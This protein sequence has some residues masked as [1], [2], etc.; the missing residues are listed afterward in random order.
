VN[1][2]DVSSPEADCE[3]ETPDNVDD[4]ALKYSVP[5]LVKALAEAGVTV[6]KGQRQEI[7]LLFTVTLVN[8]TVLEGSDTIL[9]K[10]PG[11]SKGNGKDKKTKDKKGKGKKG[12]G[13]G[14][15]NR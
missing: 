10:N 3:E 4:V 14:K 5:G 1:L 15:F 7:E 12:K 11:K 13:K 2:N 6:A 8:G 9:A